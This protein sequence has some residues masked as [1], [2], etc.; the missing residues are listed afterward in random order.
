MKNENQ[1][2]Q[3]HPLSGNY[4]AGAIRAARAIQAQVGIPGIIGSLAG[5]IDHET[6]A[7]AAALALERT[8]ADLATA[9]IQLENLARELVA[10][11]NANNS[12]NLS[13]HLA[14]AVRIA[15]AVKGGAP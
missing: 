10:F 15:R 12:I 14:E 9:R 4:S 5:I 2:A 7:D 6:G 3:A 13:G 8:Q 11:A 1:S